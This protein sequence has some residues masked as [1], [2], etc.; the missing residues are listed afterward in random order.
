MRPDLVAIPRV[1]FPPSEVASRQ[2]HPIGMPSNVAATRVVS[3]QTYTPMSSMVIPAQHGV[4]QQISPVYSQVVGD[5][6]NVVFTRIEAI[7]I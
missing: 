6:R 4:V 3:M 7:Y 5:P 2:L 1:G